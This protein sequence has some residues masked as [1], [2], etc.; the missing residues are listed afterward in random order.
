[1]NLTD[2]ELVEVDIYQHLDSYSYCETALENA[3]KLGLFSRKEVATTL[4]ELTEYQ[5]KIASDTDLAMSDDEKLIWQQA[6]MKKAG[7]TRAMVL[8]RLLMDVKRSRLGVVIDEDETWFVP[9]QKGILKIVKL[10]KDN[11]LYQ[12]LTELEELGLIRKK[13]HKKLRKLVIAFNW[14]A[15]ADCY[16]AEAELN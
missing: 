9:D 13:V 10:K 16:N 14:K 2:R 5:R 7:P 11:L 12:I 15:L 3:F 6:L 1:M 8:F 4:K